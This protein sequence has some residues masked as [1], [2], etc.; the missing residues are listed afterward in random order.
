MNKFVSGLAFLHSDHNVV[1][2]KEKHGTLLTIGG[3]IE[4]NEK[5]S[6]T[7][8]RTY[9]ESTGLPTN[10]AMWYPCFKLQ[11]SS[12]EI[13]FYR[14]FPTSI[15]STKKGILLVDWSFELKHRPQRLSPNLVWILPL[16]TS[17]AF[18]VGDTMHPLTKEE[19]Y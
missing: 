19:I 3:R 16:L 2:L 14:T 11:S 17:N 18:E 12:R 8:T 1:L 6:E 7:L 13:H 5:S 9:I 15:I 4:E 10:S